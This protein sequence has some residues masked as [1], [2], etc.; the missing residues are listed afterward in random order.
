MKNNILKII[1]NKIGYIY[2][3]GIKI[4][5][6]SNFR[7]AINSTIKINI[8]D[9]MIKRYKWGNVRINIRKSSI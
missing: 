8:L 4:L 7:S 6:K 5:I 3:D 9:N 1:K 2:I